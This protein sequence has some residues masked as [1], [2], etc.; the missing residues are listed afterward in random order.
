MTMIR[1]IAAALVVLAL[2]SG[3]AAAAVDVNA[4]LGTTI[5][6]LA[7]AFVLWLIGSMIAQHRYDAGGP[8]GGPL[9]RY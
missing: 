5:T 6:L 1:G 3:T 7:I 2:G 8:K 4:A 9:Q